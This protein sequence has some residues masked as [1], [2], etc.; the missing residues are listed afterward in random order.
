MEQQVILDGSESR[1]TAENLEEAMQAAMD[2]YAGGIRTNYAY[3]E[4]SLQIARKH[5]ERLI[6]LSDD[7]RAEDAYGLVRIFE[8]RERLLV[9]LA[10]ISHLEAR[11]ETRWHAFAEHLDY[12]ERKE[13]F[14]VFI[15]SRLE[16]GKIKIILRPL[17]AKEGAA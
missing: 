9:C 11:R 3:S 8:L 10:L 4:S 5:M 17:E 1:Y 14:R 16:Q 6:K 13:E 7:L 12:P 2:E 15:N